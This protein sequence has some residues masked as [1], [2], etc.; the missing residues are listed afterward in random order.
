MSGCVDPIERP[1]HCKTHIR[2]SGQDVA[3]A[4]GAHSATGN[5]S[6]PV[7]P[8]T[9]FSLGVES[10]GGDSHPPPGGDQKF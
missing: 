3:K 2:E 4:F 6:N 9:G 8:V 10:M 5:A 1:R 7:Q